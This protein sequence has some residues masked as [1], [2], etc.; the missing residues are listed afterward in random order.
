MAAK[1]FPKTWPPLVIREFEDIKKAYIVVRDLV[2]SLD[3]LRKRVL[4]VVN[5]HAALIDFSVSAT[6]SITSGTTQ[7]QVGATALTSRFNRVATHGNV[8]DGVKLPT[9]LA[10]KEVIILNDTATADLQVW[11]ATGDAIEAAAAD[12]VGVTKIANQE[13]VTYQAVDATTWYITNIEP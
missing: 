2:R 3:D 1:E 12:A 11:P 5:D 6:N 4:E 13:S 8:D 9:A 7:T 10:G